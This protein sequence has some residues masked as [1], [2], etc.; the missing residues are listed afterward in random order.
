MTR[1]KRTRPWDR[2][3][4]GVEFTNDHTLT[5]PILI[6]TAWLDPPLRPDDYPSE[7]TRALLFRTREPARAWCDVR[8]ERY[9][10]RTDS[11]AGWRFRPV[12]VRETVCVVETRAAKREGK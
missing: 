12:R 9:S 6:G 4:W 1:R 3:L 7:S 10:K 11:C 8:N 2:L 5:A